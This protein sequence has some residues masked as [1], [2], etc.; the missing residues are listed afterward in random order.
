M[1][2]KIPL[3]LLLLVLWFSLIG[4]L[5][6]G[7]A[8]W[9]IEGTR[10]GPPTKTDRLIVKIASYPALVRES[11]AEINRQSKLIVAD[12]YPGIGHFKAENKYVDSNYILLATFDKTKDQSVAKLIRLADQKIIY[13]WTPDY[14]QIIKLNGGQND[15]PGKF[16]RDLRLY[17][18][19][20]L[21]D[22]S[23]V[24]ST[25]LSPLIKIDKNS[26]L[27]WAVGGIFHHC[28]ESD[29]KGNIWVPSLISPSEFRPDILYDYD[30]NAIT[31]VSPGGKIIFQKSVARILVDNGYTALL[32]GVGPY[33]KDLLHLNTIRPALTSGRYWQQGD[34]LISLRN[35]STVLLYRPATN[36]I[37]WLKTGPWLC[38][39]DVRFV[40]S[41]R[42]SIFGNDIVRVF[43]DERLINGHNE[44]YVFDFKT[45][46][47]ETPFT[48]FL[49]KAGVS[50]LDEGE[51]QIQKNGDLLVEETN[52]NRVLKGTKTSILWQFVERIDSHSLAALSC[53]EFISK[54][55]FGNLNFFKTK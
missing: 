5:W 29:I 28:V 25:Q 6:F 39:H 44:E 49:R 52:K 54:E 18:P 15:W 2:R 3:W 22:G 47:V 16:K 20:L 9:H 45:G 48:Q 51:A 27:V 11:F 7:W 35:R 23:L 1:N 41:T 42:I 46:S 55:E 31:E 50:T 38:Q 26:R 17:H 32:L 12:S 43:G 8:V 24:F 30:D 13:E 21:A 37:L 14:D 19:L 53:S 10:H 4:T 40:D 36:K 34:L 33:E